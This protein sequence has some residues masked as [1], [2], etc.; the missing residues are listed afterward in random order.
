MT[1][2]ETKQKTVEAV[3]RL[4]QLGYDLKTIRRTLPALTGMTHPYVAEVLGV[5]RQ[6]VTSTM[7]GDRSN[8]LMQRRIAE[9]YGV[10]ADEIFQP[11][12][13]CD[14]RTCPLNA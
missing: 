12:P 14:C 1:Q 9:A 6:A 11:H 7:N 8:A 13:G 3:S 5:S 2:A 10:P 4:K